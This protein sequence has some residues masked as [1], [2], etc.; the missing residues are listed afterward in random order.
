[1]FA[2]LSLALLLE[3]LF[4]KPSNRILLFS[5]VKYPNQAVLDTSIL[6]GPF[7]TISIRL[8][9]AIGSGPSSTVSL[10]RPPLLVA[11]AYALDPLE[12]RPFN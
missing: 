6:M 11:T 10:F 9:L 7:S 1:M 8:K 12:Q 4:R 2:S 5:F 3:L